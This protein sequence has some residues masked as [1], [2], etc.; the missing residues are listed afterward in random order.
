MQRRGSAGD[1]GYNRRRFLAVGAS[2]VGS[3]TLSG[4]LGIIGND[5]KKDDGSNVAGQIG[6]GRSPFGDRKIPGGTSMKELPDLKGELTLYSGRGQALVGELVTF[7]ENLYDDFDVK[8]LYGNSTD[9]VQKIKTEG[10]NSP[11]DVFYSVNAGSLGLLADAGR[12]T[13]LPKDVLNEVKKQFR[14]P[15]G[16]WVGTSGRARTIPFNTNSLGKKDVPNDIFAF[17]DQS[18]FNNAMGWAPS[19]GSFQAFVTAMRILNGRQKTKQWLTRMKNSQIKK[20]YSD[21]F[22]VADAV[23]RGEIKAGFTNHYYIQRVIA[24][25]KNASIDTAFTNGDAGSMFNVA[26]ATVVDTTSDQKLAQ[27]FVHHLLSAEAQ[28][29]FA[30]K[31]FEY[32][33]IPE[34]EPLGRLPTIDELNP[35]ENL[36]LGQLSDIEPTLNLLREVNLL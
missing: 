34:V 31:T 14:D 15:Q 27:N 10:K 28:E 6:S 1:E 7:I 4:C 2:A 3:A 30:V 9:L 22:L 32:P 24:G 21:E 25:N 26:G 20:T 11:A 13:K 36:D 12:T 18:K 17:P 16:E 19:Y 8:P 29:Y 35:P 33:L 23:A 5:G